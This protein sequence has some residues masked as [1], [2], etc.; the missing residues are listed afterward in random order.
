VRVESTKTPLENRRIFEANCWRGG[1]AG[2]R[3]PRPNFQPRCQRASQRPDGIFTNSFEQGEIGPDLFR[4][5][6]RV[7]PRG[8]WFRSVPIAL[9]TP[10]VRRQKNRAGK[11]R[12]TAID[13]RHSGYDVSQRCR[14]IIEKS[15]VGSRVLLA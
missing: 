9:S 4:P 10:A 12:K 14:K 15:S 3:P 7:R 5:G 2:R 11:R 1:A 13:A 8:P 6:L